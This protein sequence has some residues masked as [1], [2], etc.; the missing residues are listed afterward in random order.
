[1]SS[2]PQDDQI[3]KLSYAIV[4]LLIPIVFPNLG[5]TS[6]DSLSGHQAIFASLQGSDPYVTFL[7]KAQSSITS[8]W[9]VYPTNSTIWVGGFATSEGASPT[10]QI[11]QFF[12]NGTSKLVATVHNL[13]LSSILPDP[14]RPQSK[15]WFT[16]NSTLVFFDTNNKTETTETKVISFPGESI[17]YLASD[18]LEHIWMSLIGP[19]GVSEIVMYDP[20]SHGNQTYQIP[21]NGAV[22]QGITV[23]SDNTIWFAEAGAKKLG[24]LVPNSGQPPTEFTPPASISLAAPIQVA[25]DQSGNVW[26]TD[27]G[28]NQFGELDPHPQTPT[29]RVYPIGYCADNCLYGLPNSIFVDA[30]NTIW[31]SEHIAGRVGHYNP[32]TGILAEYSVP[33]SNFPLVWWAMPGPFSLVWFVSFGLGQI[34]YVNASRPI[35]I[36]VSGVSQEAIVQRG[37]Y[38]RVPI[39]ATSSRSEVVSFNSSALSQDANGYTPQVYSSSQSTTVTGN[40][41]Y[42]T[43]IQ[44]FAA[45]NATLGQ[46]IIAVTTYD[47]YVSL[48][49]FVKVTVVDSSF[50]YIAEGVA[51][52]VML[53]AVA[54]TIMTLTRRRRKTFRSKD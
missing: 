45:W 10:S 44:I 35:T 41:A 18:S 25:V 39:V 38:Q 24:H 15:I 27:H 13:I 49:M 23:A 8:P 31:F 4:L 6:P 54:M 48:N 30:A 20:S 28:S 29:W 3:L 51:S 1:M 43:N 7:P 36:S 2:R 26:F 52:I 16:E 53:G 50:P 9:L 17:E 40:G 21:T 14:T 19:A 46:R 32:A 11:S 34:G 42:T 5:Y 12:I 22:V 37:S 47:S 33:G